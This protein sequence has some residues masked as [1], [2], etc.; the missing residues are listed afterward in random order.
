MNVSM[1]GFVLPGGWEWAV[2]LVLGL[3]I[4]GRR[5]P[6]VGRSMGR[7]IVEF[8]RG[9]KGIDEEIEM[10]ASRPAS[11]RSLS[12]KDTIAAEKSLEDKAD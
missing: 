3:L 12:D 5:L 8:K 2:L 10:E 11:G 6:E 9:I 7:S 1:L 4:F